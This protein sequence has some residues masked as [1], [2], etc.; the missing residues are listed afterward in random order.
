[1]AEYV[2]GSSLESDILFF[3]LALAAI[4]KIHSYLI[5]T[6]GSNANFSFSMRLAKVMLQ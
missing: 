3:I 4:V 5:P 2:F 6:F 1:M